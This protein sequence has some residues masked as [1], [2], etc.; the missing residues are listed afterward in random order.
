MQQPVQITFRDIPH[1]QEV[2]Q[3]IYAK[4]EKLNQYSDLIISCHITVEL[5]QNNQQQGKLYNSR[6]IV[7]LPEKKTIAVNHQSD[8]NLYVAIRE[9]F[10]CTVRKIEETMQKIRGDVKHHAEFMAGKI[11]RLFADK[12]FGFIEDNEGNEYYFNEDSLS[13]L[14]FNTL[15]TGDTV[16]FVASIAD[17]GPRAY[18]IKSI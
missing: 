2:T 1:S 10:D 7:T 17:E 12:N 8:E 9:A 6:I 14:D 13:H 15:N 5:A 18:R 16:Q 3:H 4:A 11:V